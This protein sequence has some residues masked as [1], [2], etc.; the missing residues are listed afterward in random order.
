MVAN[1]LNGSCRGFSAEIAC[2]MHPVHRRLGA[3]IVF[4][5]STAASCSFATVPEIELPPRT[6][7]ARGLIVIAHGVE[8]RADSW[9]LTLERAFRT[10]GA[11]ED[12]WD[13][14][15]VDWYELSLRPLAAPRRGYALG[16]AI[17]RALSERVDSYEVIHL[18]GHSAGAHVV[19]GITDAIGESAEPPVVFATF[20]DPFV[21]RSVPRL[22]W[23]VRH[24]GTNADFAESYVTRKDRVPFTNS[25]LQRAH[26]VDLTGI[27]P[28]GPDQPDNFAHLWPILYY[29]TPVLAGQEAGILISPAARLGEFVTSR[30]AGALA[31]ELGRQYPTGDVTR[32]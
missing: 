8:A 23:G 15:R 1:N 28:A 6:P 16:L 30:S 27:L 10:H 19:Q 20:L 17:G 3:A 12:L 7:Q 11:G 13:I 22:Y 4:V 9:P 24:L 25:L 32:P 14:Y 18:V 5:L 21:A 29:R 26:N 2:A 31:A